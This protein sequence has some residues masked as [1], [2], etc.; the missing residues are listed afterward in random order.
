MY[1][2]WIHERKG[3]TTSTDNYLHDTSAITNQM[4]QASEELPGKLARFSSAPIRQSHLCTIDY[5]G[6]NGHSTLDLYFVSNVYMSK[7]VHVITYDI[8]I[9]S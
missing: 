8:I 7:C 4:L 5:F 9:A 2:D 3:K 6:R 1:W